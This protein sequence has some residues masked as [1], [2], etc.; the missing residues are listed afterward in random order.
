MTKINHIGTINPSRPSLL[1]IVRIAWILLFAAILGA[2]SPQAS[3]Q[4][5][6][7]RA[8][9]A[10][11]Q[12][13]ARAAEIDVKTALQ[14]NP[15]NAAARRL[16]GEAYLF[17]QNPVAAAEELERSLSTAENT[18]T[19]LVYARALLESGQA[20]R[21]LELNQQG[22]FSSLSMEPGYQAI[23]ARAIAGNPGNGEMQRARNLVD[24]AFAA[25]PD[26]AI[27]A[28]TRAAFQLADPGA[29]EEARTL[30]ENTVSANPDYPE[31]WSLLGGVQ[32]MAGAL[33]EAEASYARAV[34]LNP[35]RFADLLS[36]L[37]IRMDQGKVDEVRTDLQPLLSSYPDHPGVNF[38]QGRLL[39][40]SGDYE[41]ALAALFSVLSAIP[42]HAG[43]LELS[44]IANINQGNLATARG[45]LDRLLAARP[46]Y[47]QGQLLS[48]NLFLQQGD[49][50]SAEEVARSILQFD[51]TNYRAIGILAT[52]LNAQGQGGAQT[53]ELYEQMANLRPDA[54]EPKLALGAALL[55]SGD[56]EGGIAQ[57]RAAR[58]LAPQS[59]QV[60]EALI[61]AHLSQG[62]IE[63]AMAEAEDYAEQQPQNPRPNIVMAR[64]AMQQNDIEAARAHFSDAETR[65]RALLAEQPDLSGLQAV[66]ADVLVGQGKLDEA[67]TLLAELPD[68]LANAP[69]VLVARG[70]IELVAN[71]PEKAEP[72]LRVALEESP[73]SMVA[74]WLGAA[75]DAQGREEEANDMLEEWLA[76]NPAD[77]MVRN[78]LANRYMARGNESSARVHYEAL[79]DENPDYV[80]AL[81]NLA[82]LLRSE[83][84]QQALAHIQRADSLVPDNPQILDTY[85]M[86]RL[87]TG[88]VDEAQS[89]NQ[90]ALDSMPSSVGIRINRARILK[91]GGQ[92]TE[93]VALLEQLVSDEN[94]SDS[95]RE[96]VET[97]LSEL[98]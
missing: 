54:P 43:S 98:R 92:T 37:E 53:L 90:R 34:E 21:L 52:A 57:F 40:Q 28:T 85:A 9:Q 15:E 79:L 82:W 18:E 10:M 71:R 62:D 86:V 35:Y 66:L 19:R 30:L 83:N 5:L 8:R 77:V 72:L 74:L 73:N 67:G 26:N 78:E 20:D 93:A 17:Q 22:A 45:Q 68:E 12:G 94:V 7:D 36:L 16:L 13:E 80:I 95:E 81:N 84:P 25:A 56:S 87:E 33:A 14:Q 60:L 39:F 32:R 91:A 88:A 97:L 1:I 48:A 75:V 2:C 59:V 61:Q 63:T 29:V 3:E 24:E 76:E 58:D 49:P 27:V 65:L 69:S 70:R 23:L 31:A 96:E 47:I 4:E 46:G 89:L 41:G 50:E 55:Q 51:A 64:I 11:A 38:L 44:A 42:D 6:L